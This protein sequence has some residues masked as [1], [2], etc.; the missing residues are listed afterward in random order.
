PLLRA[1]SGDQLLA[2]VP[3]RCTVHEAG[4]VRARIGVTR[5]L[6]G[7]VLHLTYTLHAFDPCLR[8]SV[9]WDGDGRHRWLDLATTLRA[10]PWQRSAGGSPEH[11]VDANGQH[12]HHGVTWARLDD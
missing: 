3:A 1:G 4:P 10:Q 12:W 8:V 7:G 11:I 6:P 9:A 5:E 2:T